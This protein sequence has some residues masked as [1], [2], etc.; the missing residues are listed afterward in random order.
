MIYLLR[1]CTKYIWLLLKGRGNRLSKM[2]C[3]ALNV[4]IYAVKVSH[5]C[6]II[7]SY[8][9]NIHFKV[10]ASWTLII[11]HWCYK[12]GNTISYMLAYLENCSMSQVKMCLNVTFLLTGYRSTLPWS[13][14]LSEFSQRRLSSG[15]ARAL[16]VKHAV[17]WQK[18]RTQFW[19]E[20]LSPPWKWQWV[21]L[22]K[23]LVFRFTF[24]CST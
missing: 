19:D 2:F 8:F 18:Y 5:L 17:C 12:L 14:W 21:L 6:F 24:L 13:A 4:F 23:N 11:R 16:Q 20:L 7:K 10:A 15:I 22:D 9:S 3:P 1:D